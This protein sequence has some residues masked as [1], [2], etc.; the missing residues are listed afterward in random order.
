MEQNNQPVVDNPEV[1]QTEGQ[2]A[3]PWELEVKYNKESRKLTKE[4]A[5]TYA[6]KGMN[7]DKVHSQLEE[8]QAEL[9]KMKEKSGEYSQIDEL[10]KANGYN[11]AK[12]WTRALE[13]S[14]LTEQGVPKE[15]AE[16]LAENRKFR[17]E[18]QKEKS[19]KEKMLSKQK[20]HEEFL[21]AYPDIATELQKRRALGQDSSDLI[22][23]EVFEMS[24][25]EGMTLTSAYARYENAI[26][27]EKIA[28]LESKKT[29]NAENAEASTGSVGDSGGEQFF[30][31]EQVGKMSRSEVLKNYDAIVKSKKKW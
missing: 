23:P 25:Q 9:G 22:P 21:K 8:L 30:T 24:E 17:D 7:Y 20:E 10:L 4:E 14:K 29:K 3:E 18:Y 15:I 27:R 6:Q 16:E 11:S 13:V 19:E 5:T 12:E 26:L 31:K 2:T 1:N 28:E